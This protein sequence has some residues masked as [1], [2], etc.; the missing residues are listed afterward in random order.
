MTVRPGPTLCFLIAVLIGTLSAHE[1]AQA[2]GLGV[3]ISGG[4]A[5]PTRSLITI[6]YD[7]IY[8]YTEDGRSYD[9]W[10]RD[11]IAFDVYFRPR[12][13]APEYG[14]EL[15]VSGGPLE[16][17]IS[18]STFRGRVYGTPLASPVLATDQVRRHLDRRMLSA[19]AFVRGRLIPYSDRSPYL[20]VGFGGHALRESPISGADS[21]SVN[22][23]ILQGIAGVDWAAGG[24]RLF[25]E[26]RLNLLAEPECEDDRHGLAVLSLAVGLR[27]GG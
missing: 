21:V 23:L 16:G 10:D 27:F 26:A 2:T 14:A 13:A 15:F 4:L 22:G 11:G 24:G 7:P 5:F 9:R 6:R 19:V 1:P 20:G 3:G 12:Q 17:G 25:A 8:V 18:L